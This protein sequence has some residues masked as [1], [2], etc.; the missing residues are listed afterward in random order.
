VELINQALA[1]YLD[2]DDT[3]FLEF[4][5]LSDGG[6]TPAPSPAN[7]IVFSWDLCLMIYMV[8]EVTFDAPDPF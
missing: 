2:G 3:V 7:H 5:V 8:G 6:V 4:N 1:D